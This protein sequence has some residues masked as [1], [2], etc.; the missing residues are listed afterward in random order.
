MS[1]EKINMHNE[2]YHCVHMREV[3][4]DAHIQCIN[5]DSFMQGEPRAE[6]RGWF[7]YPLLFDP[8]WKRRRCRNFEPLEDPTLKKT[9]MGTYPCNTEEAGINN[10]RFRKGRMK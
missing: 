4:G 1:E 8:V 5:P 2:C 10:D 7:Y 9:S 6:A 3:P